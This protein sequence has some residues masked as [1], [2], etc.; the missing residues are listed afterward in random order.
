MSITARPSPA[1][2]C[3]ARAS[4]RR[5]AMTRPA[6]APGGRKLSVRLALASL[7]CS[8]VIAVLVSAL[9]IFILYQQEARSAGERFSQI[10][11]AYLPGI[12][13][14]LWEVDTAG[15]DVLLNGIS[16]LPNVGKVTLLDETG[17]AWQRNA[18][19]G[20]AHLGART[21]QIVYREIGRA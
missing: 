10:E 6:S 16:R 7:L 5:R 1:P 15:T 8:A 13:A 19:A 2:A 9:Q 21:F 4:G 17:H 11:T 3:R 20:D 18:D 14:S 12:A